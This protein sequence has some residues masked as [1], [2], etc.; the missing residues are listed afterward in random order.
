MSTTRYL[1]FCNKLKDQTTSLL[2]V[3]SSIDALK[4]FDATKAVKNNK[5]DAHYFILRTEDSNDHHPMKT[6]LFFYG[7]DS[8]LPPPPRP[9]GSQY[10]S[11]EQKPV[12]DNSIQFIFFIKNGCKWPDCGYFDEEQMKVVKKILLD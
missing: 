8:S 6:I 2:G 1:I 11:E 7:T 3:Y 12:V 9:V 4:K 10:V 5:Y